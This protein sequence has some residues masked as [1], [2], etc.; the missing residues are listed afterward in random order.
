[1][2]TSSFFGSRDMPKINTIN[3]DT[4]NVYELVDASW[5][6]ARTSSIMILAAISTSTYYCSIF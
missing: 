5:H 2:L 4:A 6:D 1:M 3:A